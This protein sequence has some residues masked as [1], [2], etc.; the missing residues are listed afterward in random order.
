MYD[1]VGDI[2]AALKQLDH[3]R[4]AWRKSLALEPNDEVRKKLESGGPK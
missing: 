4:E 2:Y 3:A 1:H